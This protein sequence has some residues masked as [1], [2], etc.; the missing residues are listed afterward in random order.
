MMIQTVALKE[1][2]FY[3]YHG[4]YPEEQLTGNNFSVDVDV[5]FTPLDGNREDI[6]NTVNYEVINEVV[7]HE[8]GQTKKMLETVVQCIIN[9][10]L[11][12][13]PYLQTV[14]VGIKKIGPCMPGEIG[15]SF[16]ELRYLK[17]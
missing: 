10:L 7:R 15:Y 11:S 16:V 5:T 4:F 2:K 17:D 12:A 9:K 6:A 3:A 1:I 14:V 8:M 13:Y